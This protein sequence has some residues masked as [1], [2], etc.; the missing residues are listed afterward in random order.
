MVK[1]LRKLLE[2]LLRKLLEKLLRRLLEKL[3]EKLLARAGL[4][5]P[6]RPARGQ[7]T[8]ASQAKPGWLGW[9]G[10]NAYGCAPM[11]RRAHAM[12]F[13]TH[14]TMPRP[15]YKKIPRL[16]KTD[17]QSIRGWGLS[18]DA[19]FLRRRSLD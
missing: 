6:G 19:L 1:L 10:A 13:D 4:A 9:S 5:G 12:T 3:L 18:A 7:A 2:T 11:C 14:A 17:K 15:E 8:K 16:C